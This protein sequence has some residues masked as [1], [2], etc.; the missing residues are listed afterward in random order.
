[1][2][3]E[4]TAVYPETAFEAAV[5][6]G[7]REI[8]VEAGRKYLLVRRFGLDVA[9]FIEAS[10]G[11]AVRLVEAKAFGAQ[12]QGGVGFGNGHGEGP[13]V[14]LLCCAEGS[15]A[16]LAPAV[17]WI[18]ADATLPPG[19]ARYACFDCETAKAAAMGGVRKGKQNNF[20]VSALRPYYREWSV[21]LSDLKGFLL[22]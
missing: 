11:V 20:R 7:I 12:R 17:R 19:S 2:I 14:E 16:L 1:M 18:L 6:E 3:A 21:L 9:V 13:Q 22:E 8:L 5:I 4:P 10:A 15:M